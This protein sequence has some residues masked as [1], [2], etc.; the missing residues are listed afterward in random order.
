MFL[1]T[2]AEL[3][4]DSL[5]YHQHLISGPP[6]APSYFVLALLSTTRTLPADDQMV[7]Y[8]TPPASSHALPDKLAERL[9]APY[10]APP[11]VGQL[12]TTT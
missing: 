4:S 11:Y 10:I 8:S 3:K 9:Q 6:Q 2:L 1:I 7:P 5:T 12:L